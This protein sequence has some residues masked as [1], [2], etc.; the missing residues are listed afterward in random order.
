MS[1]ENFRDLSNNNKIIEPIN[2]KIQA[3]NNQT[4]IYNKSWISACFF[5][6]ILLL[7]Y[8]EIIN[9]H[10]ALIMLSILFLALSI[11]I[12]IMFR[13]REEKL[14]KLISGESLIAEWIL[15]PEQKDAYVN[16]LFK[17]ELLNNSLILISISFISIIVF[18]VFIA[19]IEEGKLAMLGV[20]I[21]LILLL[22]IFAYGMPYYYRYKNKKG[23]GIVLIGKKYAYINGYFHN[24]DFPLSGIKKVKIIQEPFEGIS[25]TYFYTD[26]TLKHSETLQIPL[27][28]TYYAKKWINKLID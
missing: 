5:V 28:E 8:L 12:A 11:I 23:D 10:P 20:L 24:W 14:K 6:A 21:G 7:N 1:K 18:G 26:R 9:I 27:S 22:T 25:L 16:Q 13:S 17:K 3:Q 15:T 2:R 19:I 4:S